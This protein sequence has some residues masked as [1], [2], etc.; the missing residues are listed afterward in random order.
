MHVKP[1]SV[2]AGRLR[3]VLVDSPAGE[4]LSAVRHL[5]AVLEDRSG[6]VAVRGGLRGGGKVAQ[7]HVST[8][9]GKGSE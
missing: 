9:H 4:V 1:Q 7:T 6:H 2:F 5:R 3:D 8:G